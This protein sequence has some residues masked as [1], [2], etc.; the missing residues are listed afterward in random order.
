MERL[1]RDEMI[2]LVDRLQRGEGD[3]EQAGEWIDQLNQSVPHPAISDL[4]FYSDEELSPEEI[5]DKALSYR[6]IEL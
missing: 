2:A 5:V 3:D 6:P 4:I 1:T